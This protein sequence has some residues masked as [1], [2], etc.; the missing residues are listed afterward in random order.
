MK[1]KRYG[2]LL[3]AAAV[4]ACLFPVQAKADEDYSDINYWTTKCSNVSSLTSDETNACQAF[5]QYAATQSSTLK[6]Q[7]LAIDAQRSDVQT[8]IDDY[9]A[10]IAD[11]QSQ[12]D[13]LNSQI[14][15]LNSQIDDLND[16]IAGQEDKV[17]DLR[18]KVNTQIENSQSTMRL[19]KYVDIL[20]GAK[21]FGD[22]LKIAAG[23]TDLTEHNHSTLVSLNDAIDQLTASQ[24]ELSSKQTELQTAQDDILAKQYEAQLTEQ[25]YENQKANLENQSNDTLTLISSLQDASDTIT[26]AQKEEQERQIAEQQAKAEAEAAAAAAAQAAQQAANNSGGS[27]NYGS[28]SSSS[29]SS[30]TNGSQSSDAAIDG[31]AVVAYARQFLGLPYVWGGNGPNYFDCSG[32]TKYVYAHFGIVLGRTSYVQET[33]GYAVSYADAQPGDLIT[34]TGHCGIYAGNGMVINAMNPSMGIR[35]CPIGWITNGNMIIHRLW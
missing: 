8:N 7:L 34:W 3:A 27:G 4:T 2:A 6:D 11:Y 30:S 24:Q 28:S 13:T 33:A 14:S 35:E 26:E 9:Q 21:T 5:L 18:A 10:K 12:I 29:G 15:D 19:S 17:A 31:Y 22:F 32:L 1:F 16:Q 25:D 20:M 23:L